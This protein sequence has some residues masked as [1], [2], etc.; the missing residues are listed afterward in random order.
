MRAK[1]SPERAQKMQKEENRESHRRSQ[2]GI[3]PTNRNT[4]VGP[5]GCGGTKPETS[6][7]HQ[8]PAH[9]QQLLQKAFAAVPISD[10]LRKA[11]AG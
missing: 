7:Q 2:R 1:N 9:Q 5:L 4:M 3:A 6:G 8:H 10:F 11:P